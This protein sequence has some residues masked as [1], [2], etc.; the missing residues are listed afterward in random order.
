MLLAGL[1]SALAGVWAGSRFG[2]GLVPGADAEVPEAAG[3]RWL[4]PGVLVLALVGI[5]LFVLSASPPG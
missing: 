1:V 5:A 3:G 4:A 2:D